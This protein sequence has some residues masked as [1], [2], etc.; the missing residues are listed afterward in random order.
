MY[1]LL[2]CLPR[3]PRHAE[4][5]G[6]NSLL[7]AALYSSL[8]GTMARRVLYFPASKACTTYESCLSSTLDILNLMFEKQANFT[9]ASLIF[10]T[11]CIVSGPVVRSYTQLTSHSPT[12]IGLRHWSCGQYVAHGSSWVWQG[13]GSR[14]VDRAYSRF[15]FAARLVLTSPQVLSHRLLDTAWQ[16][17]HHRSP[18][19]SLGTGSMASGCPFR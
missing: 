9:V 8:A 5:R 2:L 7:S 13:Y 17:L 3:R 19:S 16:P 1:L 15:S 6:S 10:V 11:N 12:I 4:G 18:S 14:Y